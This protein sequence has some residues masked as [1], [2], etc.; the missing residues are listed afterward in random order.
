MRSPEEIIIKGKT[1]KEI[2]DLHSFWL[3]T[4]GNDGRAHCIIQR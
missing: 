2:L 4:D 3:I 1:L